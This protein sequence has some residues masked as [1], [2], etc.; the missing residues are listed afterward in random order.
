MSSRRP[1]WW[2]E[3]E[4]W[5]PGHP[6]DRFRWWW[7]IPPLLLFGLCG[8]S[9]AM[10]ESGRGFFWFPWFPILFFLFFFLIGRRRYRPRF[11]P[12][13]SLVNATSRLAEGDYSV[14]V[15]EVEGGPLREVVASFNAMASRLESASA[16]RRQLLADLGHELR[17]PL[18]VLQGEIEALIDG[19]HPPDNEM[20]DRLLEEIAVMSRLLD[21]LRTLSLSEAGE[22]RLE[23][24][25]VDL[26]ALLEDAKS[27]HQKAAEQADVSIEVETTPAIIEAD[28]LRVREIVSN[29][30]SNAI[31]H[32]NP[33]DV[34]R[35]LNRPTAHAQEVTVVDQGPGIPAD[36]LPRVFER[37]VKGSDSTGTGL[38]LSIARDL[39]Q[40]HGGEIS[41]SSP[42]EGGTIISFSI[43]T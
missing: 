36:L 40:A 17:T 10:K 43:P 4:Q 12:V 23:K 34:V 2:P 31:R 7:M 38:G 33:G 37:F 19:V 26:A 14:R 39:V 29:L 16:Q 22:L 18:T 11:F 8:I 21:D 32:S 42:S 1:E 24:E 25:E 30:L 3:G 20:L 35:V 27:S 5:P 28:P 15:D 6:R 13:R 41:A 9:F